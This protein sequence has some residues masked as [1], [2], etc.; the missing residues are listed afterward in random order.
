MFRLFFVAFLGEARNEKAKHAHESPAVMSLPLVVLAVFAL[1]GG[2][3]GI[4]NIY[5]SQFAADTGT[6]FRRA[7][8]V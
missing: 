2:Y 5:G 3:I 6:A 4:T 7:A 8:S 1:V